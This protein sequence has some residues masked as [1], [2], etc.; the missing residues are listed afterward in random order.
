MSKYPIIDRLLGSFGQNRRLPKVTIGLI[1]ACVLVD[2]AV[3]FDGTLGNALVFVPYAAEQQPYRFLTAAFMHAGFWHLLLNMYALWILGSILEPLMGRVRYFMLYLLSALA[4]NV[5]V[6]LLADPSGISWLTGVVG[7][8][9]AVFGLLGA[10]L[11]IARVS[12]A[13]LTNLLVIIGLNMAIGFLPDSNISWQAHVGGFIGGVVL[14]SMLV[15]ARGSA[16]LDAVTYI[17]FSGALVGATVWA[18]A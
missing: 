4:G 15:R 14:V 13:D 2:L 17:I 18:L 12:G 8:S 3:T 9:G 7:A 11:V 6:L 16:V 10:Q 5:S 1:V